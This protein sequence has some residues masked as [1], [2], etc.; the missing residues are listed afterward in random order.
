MIIIPI[1]N[2]KHLYILFLILFGS[3][4]FHSSLYFIINVNQYNFYDTDTWYSIRQ[5][6]RQTHGENIEYDSM[7]NY[8]EGRSIDWGIALPIFYSLFVNKYDSTLEIFNKVGFLPPILSALFVLLIYFLVSK[9]FS[10]TVGFYSSIL[11][12]IGTGI[13]FQN[14][15]F[16]VIDHHLLES[17][18]FTITILCFLLL[19]KEKSP[20]WAIPIFISVVILF[21]T[22][23]LWIF[24]CGILIIC[25]IIL[26]LYYCFLN[27]IVIL[28][29]TL[30]ITVGILYVKDTQWFSLLW[31]VEPISEVATSDLIILIFRFNILIPLFI[32]GVILY[33]ISKKEFSTTCLL[34]ISFI[35]MILTYRFTRMEYLL[36]PFVLI[37]S[38][39]FIDKF[40]TK[41]SP[42][43]SYIIISTFLI[44][45]I[46]IGSVVIYDFVET[47]NNNTGWNDALLYLQEQEQGGVLSWWDYGH[48]IVAVSSQPPL[49]DPFQDHV[50]DAAKIFTGE[51]KPELQNYKYIII[52]KNDYKFYDAM[53]WYSK[54]EVAYEN[55][56]LKKI[57]CG[58]TNDELI[59]NNTLIR[60]YKI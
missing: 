28:T 57:I 39:Y 11:L 19:V 48:W 22:S 29:S 12:S 52:T 43:I 4:L 54:S 13:Y 45:S 25:I 5:I 3:L 53:L 40:L 15:L 36:T 59:F 26:F 31:W 1:Q 44:F 37:L 50:M 34:L 14:C 38:A 46:I 55:S 47:A 9:L 30:I 8:P 58:E 18:L 6:D 32:L 35:L 7:L 51:I 49:T 20:L 56:Y 41:Q 17:V 33:A 24:F 10:E 16:G 27:R 42:K 2:K 21:F 23:V 60:I